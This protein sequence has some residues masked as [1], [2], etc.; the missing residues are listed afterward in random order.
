VTSSDG[1]ADV[2]EAESAGGAAA[3]SGYAESTRSARLKASNAPSTSAETVVRSP[4]NTVIVTIVPKASRELRTGSGSRVQPYSADAANTAM[5]TAASVEGDRCLELVLVELVRM[6]GRVLWSG[7]QRHLFRVGLVETGNEDCTR[8]GLEQTGCRSCPR[9]F[10]QY[11]GLTSCGAQSR[12]RAQAV[13]PEVWRVR[14]VSYNMHRAIGSESR[15]PSILAIGEV[16]G[17]LAP[18]VVALNEVVRTPFLA[19]QPMRL[20]RMLRMQRAYAHTTANCS[21]SFGNAILV[22][23]RIVD[24]DAAALPAD[25]AEPRCVLF[26][27]VDI[28]SSRFTFGAT[29]L[30]VHAAPRTAQLDAL[31]PLLRAVRGGGAGPAP[32]HEP[33]ADLP[34]DSLPSADEGSPLVVAGDFNAEES[35]I[36][37]LAE[38]SGLSAAPFVP[39]FPSSAP[40]FALDRVLFSDHWRLVDVSVAARAASDHAALVVDL[41]RVR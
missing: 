13:H 18:D 39:T 20:A 27:D 19:D 11:T 16:I 29:H 33:G 8:R 17:A 2:E 3:S 5:V 24:S 6:P 37:R 34:V 9:T 32:H 26:A 35:E 1:T 31:S 12:G 41:E 40:R 23:G 22:R 38:A 36:V 21:M 30:D 10:A 15:H 25:G 28:D 14:V 4:P 7:R